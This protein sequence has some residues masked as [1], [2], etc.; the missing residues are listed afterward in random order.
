NGGFGHGFP[1][2]PITR[3]FSSLAETGRNM[4]LES[5]AGVDNK[6]KVDHRVYG[7]EPEKRIQSPM[8]Q[9]VDF[10]K[11]SSLSK[12]HQSTGQLEQAKS[13]LH[14]CYNA[15]RR[16]SRLGELDRSQITCRLCDIL[17]AQEFC[18]DARKKI[19][20]EINT[21]AARGKCTA[22][23]RRLKVSL[24]EVDILEGKFEQAFLA[25]H[26]LKL[27]FDS[28]SSADVGEQRL[29]VRSVIASSRLFHYQFRYD[30]AIREWEEACS[31][32]RKYRHCFKPEGFLYGLIQFSI[33]V[34]R[35]RADST[36]NRAYSTASKSWCADTKQSFDNGC[37]I[38]TREDPDYWIPTIP[39]IWVPYLMS[40]MESAE[41]TWASTNV[42]SSLRQRYSSLGF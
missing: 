18:S 30:D 25:A 9:P 1:V 16:N 33:S 5:E 4:A 6:S 24:M 32:V 38:L 8:D 42:F 37:V 34:A 7:W 31:L 23:L 28:V 27:A 29:H 40:V 17:C 36:T 19:E 20:A 14:V 11:L 2:N 22:S 12:I 3:P 26:W 39:K 35:I 10:K 21:S 41:P 15:I 13:Y